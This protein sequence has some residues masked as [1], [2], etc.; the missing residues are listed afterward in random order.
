MIG[1]WRFLMAKSKTGPSGGINMQDLARVGARARLD[2]LKA[3]QEALLAAFPDLRASSSGQGRPAR[4]RASEAAEP[5]RA[6]RRGGMSPAQ[7]KAVRERLRAYW[8]KRR[9][10]KAGGDGGPAAESSG[11]KAKGRRRGRRK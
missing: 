8:A 9:A 6:R 7:R 5:A 11:S 10:E 1:A 4:A 3:E 2:S